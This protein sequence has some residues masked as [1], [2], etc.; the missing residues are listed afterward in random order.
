MTPQQQA[1]ADLL[2]VSLFKL[3]EQFHETLARLKERHPDQQETLTDI[4][5]DVEKMIDDT[6]KQYHELGGGFSM[7]TIDEIHAKIIEVR[8][9]LD[10]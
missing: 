6:L 5:R 9:L 1:M 4:G 7:R 3:G 10:R 2:Q 8:N